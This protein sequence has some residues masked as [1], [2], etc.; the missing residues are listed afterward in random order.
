[1]LPKI[2]RSQPLAVRAPGDRADRC[3]VSAQRLSQHSGGR[4]PDLYALI[5][6]TGRNQA[7]IRLPGHATDLGDAV[8][9]AG[10]G[11]IDAPQFSPGPRIPQTE[12]SPEPGRSDALSLG[13]PSESVIRF[14]VALAGDLQ[15]DAPRARIE[16]S[17]TTPVPVGNQPPAV[18]TPV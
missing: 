11:A 13:T 15:R 16:D 12:I 9:R 8:V 6:S 14:F 2:L 7:S 18:G 4:I 5:V 3:V 10:V 1:V 17:R